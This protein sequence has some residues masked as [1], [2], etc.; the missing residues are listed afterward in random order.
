MTPAS[1]RALGI[2]LSALLIAGCTSLSPQRPPASPSTTP[3]LATPSGATPALPPPR[4]DDLG[5]P[6]DPPVKRAFAFDAW[7]P[8]DHLDYDTDRYDVHARSMHGTRVIVAIHVDLASRD[9]AAADELA[10]FLF[11]AFD[12]AWHVFGG[13]AYGEARVVVRGPEEPCAFLSATQVGFPICYADHAWEPGDPGRPPHPLTDARIP[14]L[15][16]HELFHMWNGGTIRSTPTNATGF[17]EEAW[18]TEGATTYYAARLAGGE[19]Y[20]RAMEVEVAKYERLLPDAGGLSF[21]ELAARTPAPG[22]APDAY[23]DMLYTRGALVSRLLDVELAKHGKDLD[24]VARTL[25]LASIEGR[26]FTSEDVEIAAERAADADLTAF[27]D[28][29]VRGSKVATS[30]VDPVDH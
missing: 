11:R 9:P 20:E 12:D 7:L 13:Y 22:S 30:E 3:L 4:V 1:S 16:I 17:P 10:E 27:F 8:P 5:D 21:E 26:T 24:D 2:I 25:Y 23:V 6:G 14:E 29:Y 15:V 28:A 18:W 19:E